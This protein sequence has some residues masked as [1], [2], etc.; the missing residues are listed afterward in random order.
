M[1]SSQSCRINLH[2]WTRKCTQPIPSHRAGIECGEWKDVGGKL[3]IP[4]VCSIVS[5]HTRP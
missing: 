3:H 2:V 1:V 4:N 5:P